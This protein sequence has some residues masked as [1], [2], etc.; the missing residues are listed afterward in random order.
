MKIQFYSIV[1][2]DL[3]WIKLCVSPFWCRSGSKWKGR[4]LAH[5]VCI[6][7]TALLETTLV[8][9]LLGCVFQYMRNQESLSVNQSLALRGVKYTVTGFYS[10]TGSY[11]LFCAIFMSG[12]IPKLK[13]MNKIFFFILENYKN[14][15]FLVCI[16]SFILLIL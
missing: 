10:L 14:W 16:S 13:L 5:Q 8:N 7:I 1:K 15:L 11:P 3:I 12:I 6:S 2:L 4:S 9:I